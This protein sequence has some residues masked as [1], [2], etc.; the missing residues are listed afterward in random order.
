M[1]IPLAG[2]VKCRTEATIGVGGELRRP[3]RVPCVLHYEIA[4]PRWQYTTLNGRR[5]WFRSKFGRIR[6]LTGSS[7]SKFKMVSN[8]FSAFQFPSP[9]F[10]WNVRSVQ[11]GA[12]VQNTSVQFS[13]FSSDHGLFRP[14]LGQ[15]WLARFGPGSIQSIGSPI[16]W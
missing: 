14:W 13:S 16:V 11:F 1:P 15:T 12:Q 6:K 4:K 9:Q 10:V 7:R 5:L 2:A 8:Q 3:T